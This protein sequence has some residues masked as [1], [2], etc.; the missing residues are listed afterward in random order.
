M[1]NAAPMRELGMLT[2]PLGPRSQAGLVLLG[3]LL[4]AGCDG[5]L[6]NDPEIDEARGALNGLR[7]DP[8]AFAQNRC[9]RQLAAPGKAAFARS[10]PAAPNGLPAGGAI[11]CSALLD[12]GSAHDQSERRICA[13]LPAAALARLKLAPVPDEICDG[14][15]LKSA[16]RDAD[17]F[18]IRKSEKAAW[19]ERVR[20][21][22]AKAKAWMESPGPAAVRA[23]W[24]EFCRTKALLLYDKGGP[25]S[26]TDATL[27][28]TCFARLL[29]VD[30]KGAPE[31]ML[32]ASGSAK[33]E[34]PGFK[35]TSSAIKLAN[36]KA[37]AKAIDAAREALAKALP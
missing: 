1:L 2:R 16:F 28:Y 34:T 5:E 11:A 7:R 37:R 23:H 32:G 13:G 8:F 36:D 17:N 31:A 27:E 26:A 10:A 22:T 18:H 19:L 20:A 35:T 14:P 25:S 12:G 21:A 3:A 24:V 15:D 6:Q 33:A 29:W 9:S 4:L 30:S